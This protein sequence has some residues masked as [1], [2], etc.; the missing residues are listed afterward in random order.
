MAIIKSK[1][2]VITKQDLHSQ[3]VMVIKRM[4]LDHSPKEVAEMMSSFLESHCQDSRPDVE[5]QE[6]ITK[7]HKQHRWLIDFVNR[8]SLALKHFVLR[9]K[10]VVITLMSSHNSASQQNYN[11]WYITFV[12]QSSNLAT[13][14]RAVVLYPLAHSKQR[15]LF[16]PWLN[17]LQ[18]D[19]GCFCFIAVPHHSALCIKGFAA[20]LHGVVPYYQRCYV[21]LEKFFEVCLDCLAHYIMWTK[22]FLVSFWL[23]V[24]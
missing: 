4:L 8:L 13:W 21:R 23:F 11:F 16:A 22:N 10:V 14:R 18:T 17:N 19:C 12:S 3:C 15:D 6:F 7:F 2:A 20:I 1:H 24:L 9:S 5:L